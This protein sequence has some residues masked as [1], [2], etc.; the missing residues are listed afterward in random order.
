ME[1][2]R[3]AD[4]KAQQ[5]FKDA[6]TGHELSQSVFQDVYVGCAGRRGLRRLRGGLMGLAARLS[7]WQTR[8]ATAC[9]VTSGALKV[10][11]AVAGGAEQVANFFK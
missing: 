4:I 3:R 9:R 2:F 8:A 5:S 10:H 7:H 6:K 1:S 11:T